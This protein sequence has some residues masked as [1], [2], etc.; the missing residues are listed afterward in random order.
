MGKPQKIPISLSDDNKITVFYDGACPLCTREMGFYKR[1]KGADSIAW[2][3]VSRCNED[4]V[5][6][7]LSKELAL[8]RFHIQE[9]DG[10]IVSGAEGFAVLWAALPAFRLFGRVARTQP[11]IWILEKVNQQFLKIRP[12]LQSMFR[13]CQMKDTT[14]LPDW[15][16]RDLRSD[17]AGET[18]AIA[19][20][21]GILAVT[22][23]DE[24]RSFAESHLKTEGQHLELIESVLPPDA[25][26]SLLP[27][28]R[29]AGFL[30]GALPA[31]FGNAA[32]YRTIDAVET[33]VDLHYSKQVVRLSH[34]E[35]FS[36]IHDI[37]ERCQ[38]DE[39]RH[40]DEARNRLQ[41]TPSMLSEAWCWLIGFGSAVAVTLA[42]RI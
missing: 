2:M 33:F 14:S 24:I 16:I 13:D 9:K 40:R 23:N 11:L 34:E 38:T 6:P 17:H 20:Y 31:M 22:N 7:D 37:L 29:A 15:L 30:T 18:G 4:Y 27:L 26:S 41:N 12:R 5:A 8:R 36:E 10:P 39:I 3:D 1:Q 19:I 35:R 42:R 25:R 32:V 21:R 28:W